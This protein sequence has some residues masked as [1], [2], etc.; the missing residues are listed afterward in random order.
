[1]A[2]RCGGCGA[3]VGA[4]ALENALAGLAPVSRDDVLIGLH[5]PDDAAAVSVPDGK[6][7]V[8]TVDAFRSFIDDPY[9]FGQVAANH[10]LSDLYAMGAEPQTALSIVTIPYG[11]ENKVEE[12]L[13]QMLQGALKALNEAGAALVGGHTSEGESCPWAFP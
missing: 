5:E 10:A 12:L 8:H 7:M 9:V 6:V 13:A 1:M 4:T 3:K 11:N 2:M